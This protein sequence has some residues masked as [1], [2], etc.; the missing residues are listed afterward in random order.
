MVACV[1]RVIMAATLV[2]RR[3]PGFR[4]TAL[5]GPHQ[6]EAAG[7]HRRWGGAVAVAV[8]GRGLA[9]HLLERGGEPADAGDPDVERDLRDRV[10]GL[11]EAV[12]GALDPPSLQV[13]VRSLAELALERA[14][15][16]RLGG[17][18]GAGQR[19]DVEVRLGVAAVDLVAGGAQVD[20][21][22][23][24]SPSPPHNRAV[25]AASSRTIA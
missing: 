24:T 10:V 13:P 14:D 11:P 4:K 7:D 22:N 15:E 16:V 25:L 17:E 8:R 20:H 9:H 21:S 23:A 5:A 1:R 19:G 2:A 3:V 6:R 12:A 18:C